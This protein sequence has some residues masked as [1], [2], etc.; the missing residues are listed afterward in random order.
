MTEQLSPLQWPP[1]WANPGMVD[2]LF[3][4]LP[5]IG[6]KRRVHRA[7]SSQLL[8]RSDSCFALWPSYLRTAHVL[9]TVAKSIQRWFRWPNSFYIPRDPCEILF[10]SYDRSLDRARCILEIAE[11]LGVPIDAFERLPEMCFGDLIESVA[12]DLETTHEEG[13]A[14]NVTGKE[15]R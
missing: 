11:S 15:S 3:I 5:V 6:L 8:A 14:R 4:D 1:A 2:R 13:E 12:A 9:F 10:F 7:I